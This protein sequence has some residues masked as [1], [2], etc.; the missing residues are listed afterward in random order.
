M[1]DNSLREDIC[2]NL[3]QVKIGFWDL[4]GEVPNRYEGSRWAI[5]RALGIYELERSLSKKCVSFQYSLL[6]FGFQFGLSNPRQNM[7]R[8]L[9]FSWMAPILE[10]TRRPR[11][12]ASDIAQN[13][14]TSFMGGADVDRVIL[15]R[16]SCKNPLLLSCRSWSALLHV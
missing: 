4:C 15:S 3:R 10:S 14:N 2:R 11:S 12:Q 13:Q 6:R 9:R 7:A 5:A 8:A 16:I 1:R